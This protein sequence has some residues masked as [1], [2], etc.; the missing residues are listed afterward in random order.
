MLILI[1]RQFG[2]ISD[3][4]E[5][6]SSYGLPSS[7]PWCTCFIQF[8]GSG[9]TESAHTKIYIQNSQSDFGVCIARKQTCL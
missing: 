5:L 8:K 7:R 6:H 3:V 9:F 2:G 4:V 1:F